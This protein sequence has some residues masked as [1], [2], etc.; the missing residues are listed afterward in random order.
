MSFVLIVG[1]SN[2]YLFSLAFIIHS[3]NL[4]VLIS[5]YLILRF[6]KHEYNIEIIIIKTKKKEIRNHGWD[7]FLM[8]VLSHQ[9]HYCKSF[10][11]GCLKT[12]Q[13]DKRVLKE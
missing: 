11:A 4:V 13:I 9:F 8:E 1:A 10:R 6:R 12:T 7:D 3:N 5:N 2:S